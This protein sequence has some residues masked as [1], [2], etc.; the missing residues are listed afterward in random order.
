M[1]FDFSEIILLLGAGQGLF[2]AIAFILSRGKRKPK[3]LFAFIL[4][5]TSWQ[6]FVY[7]LSI[8]GNILQLPHLSFTPR[9][10]ML[11]IGPAYYFYIKF[12][13][14][15]RLRLKFWDVLHLIPS[16]IVLLFYKD[17]FV[18]SAEVKASI[19]RNSSMEDPL[20][21]ATW[22][23]IMGNLIVTSGYFLATF[24]LIRDEEEKLVD[25]ISDNKLL[26]QMSQLKTMTAGYFIY[27]VCF[28]ITLV[29][30]FIFESY[31]FEI[32]YGWILTK[33]LFIH[34]IGYVAVNQPGLFSAERMDLNRISSSKNK[35]EKSG[36]SDEQAR[37]YYQ[38]LIKLMEEERPYL[39]SKLKLDMLA[40]KLSISPNLLSQVIN[41]NSSQNF[42]GFVN[43]YRISY[44]QKLLQQVDPS[45]DT[46][47]L[48]I[49]M[50]SG[51]NTKA[52]FNRNFKKYT[53]QTPTSFRKIKESQ[54]S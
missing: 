12:L 49:A 27:I 21:T 45:S 22:L 18:L 10:L 37:F 8:S 39:N 25:F 3:L 53:G 20:S 36:L 2:L 28:L 1:Q 7:S 16:I 44:A 19:L 26:D 38:E 6:L 23:Y 17:F 24:W 14:N 31:T 54:N 51:F 41:Q 46:T 4:L 35:Y 43:H 52:S 34:A 50:E 33:T 32:D 11:L 13:V 48:E 30:L 9:P 40:D 47:I 5:I 29:L 15:G 42:Y